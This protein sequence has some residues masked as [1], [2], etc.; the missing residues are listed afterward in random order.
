MH[1]D[2]RSTIRFTVLGVYSRRPGP[3]CLQPPLLPSAF[4][5]DTPDGD[6]H[7][8]LALGLTMESAPVLAE[9]VKWGAGLV[10][11]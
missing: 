10:V 8:L 11:V 9:V 5:P 4:T 1:W 6:S 2:P 7:L 3:A